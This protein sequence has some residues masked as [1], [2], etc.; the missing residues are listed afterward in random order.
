VRKH[1]AH[2]YTFWLYWQDRQQVGIPG[3]KWRNW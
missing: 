3:R 1:S 2:R